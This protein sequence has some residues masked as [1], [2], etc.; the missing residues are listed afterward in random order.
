MR[1][2]IVNRTELERRI[3]VGKT[4][5]LAQRERFMG[6]FGRA[7]SHWKTDGTRV[8][9][10]DL[11][12]SASMFAAL[13]TEF[14]GD[15]F[16]S[17]ES[18]QVSGPV[19]RTAEWSWM[20][21]PIDGTNNFALGVPMT[22]ISLALLH[23]GVPAY[24]FVYDFGRRALLHGG[25]GM[26]VHEDDRPLANGFGRSGVDKVVA[27][28]TPLDDRH[29]PG[30]LAIVSRYK[31]RAFGSG[32]LHLAYASLGMIDACLDFTVRVWDIAAAAAFCGETGAEMH[33]FNGSPFPL[34]QFDLKMT[35]TRYL[36]GSPHACAEILAA[37]KAAG[38][39]P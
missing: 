24:G 4:A 16:F 31:L 37:F 36:A 2:A 38:W 11:A 17:E 22:A 18:A 19:A 5:T 23:D 15:Q 33:F 21:D 12:I 27:V 34:Q 25:S 14:P 29:I 32:A 20:L 9:D 1:L 39:E 28:H 10:S 30:L 35:P 8:T 13:S 6:D 3:G 7:L 26:G